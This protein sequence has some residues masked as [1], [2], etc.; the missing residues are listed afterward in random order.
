MLANTER[1]LIRLEMKVRQLE[2]FNKNL[3]SIAAMT[4]LAIFSWLMNKLPN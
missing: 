1:R 2:D 3:K 4:V